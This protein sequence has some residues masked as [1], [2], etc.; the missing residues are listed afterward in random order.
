M[1]S[2]FNRDCRDR[3]KTTTFFPHFH[4]SIFKIVTLRVYIIPLAAVQKWFKCVGKFLDWYSLSSTRHG[5]LNVVYVVKV[6]SFQWHFEFREQKEVAWSQIWRIRRVFQLLTPWLVLTCSKD[7]LP[8][9]QYCGHTRIIYYSYYLLSIYL[10][11]WIPGPREILY[12]N[13]KLAFLINTHHHKLF[14]IFRRFL[15][16]VLREM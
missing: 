1:H 3:T 2:R 10:S 5:L 9:S 7:E 8:G 12:A 11:L 16:Q 14:A 4:L 6:T 15:W 13:Q